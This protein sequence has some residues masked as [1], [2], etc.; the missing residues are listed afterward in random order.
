MANSTHKVTVAEC[1]ECETNI[2]IHKPLQ[3]GQRLICPECDERLVV[4]RLDPLELD[5]A[6]DD[7]NDDNEEWD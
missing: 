4:R 1:P 3:L 2:R 6:F 5:W 7:Y